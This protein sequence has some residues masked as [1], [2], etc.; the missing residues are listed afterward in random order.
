LRKQFEQSDDLNLYMLD[1]QYPNYDGKCH[2]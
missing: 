1:V 2:K